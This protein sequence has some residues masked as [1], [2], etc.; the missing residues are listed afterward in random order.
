MV[1]LAEFKL[2]VSVLTNLTCFEDN[3]M[4]RSRIK[5]AALSRSE[6]ESF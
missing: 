3:G 1:T 4:K 5:K 6:Y 2:F